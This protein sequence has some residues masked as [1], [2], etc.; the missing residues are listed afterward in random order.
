MRWKHAKAGKLHRT[1]GVAE[2]LEDVGRIAAETGTEQMIAA[3]VAVASE[4]LNRAGLPVGAHV[5]NDRGEWLT[6][7]D[8][9]RERG[10]E[11]LTQS[12]PP[13]FVTR[14]LEFAAWPVP[15][16]S[17]LL[18]PEYF[19]AKTMLAY[20]V[21]QLHRARS[22]I[23]GVLEWAMRLGDSASTLRTVLAGWHIAAERGDKELS[24]SRKSNPEAPA[25]RKAL[26]ARDDELKAQGL[27]PMERYRTIA[28]E[29]GEALANTKRAVARARKALPL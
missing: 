21:L 1:V 22:D 29:R 15:E 2:S 19:A 27:P 28:E 7:P 24:D 16:R 10:R 18:S 8:N 17:T 9:W 20:H 4:T 6:L 5:W 26:L 14:Q 12:L 3:A 13:D 11:Q 25:K 23:D